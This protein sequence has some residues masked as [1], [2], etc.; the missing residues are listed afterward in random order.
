MIKKFLQFLS[1]PDTWIEIRLIGNGKSIPKFYKGT[2]ELIND[3]S[4]LK[5]QNENNFNVYYG[6]LPRKIKPESGGGSKEHVI[7]KADVLWLDVDV[8]SVK[9]PEEYKDLTDE[10][11]KSKV[12]E[13]FKEKGIEKEPRRKK[14]LSYDRI[15]QELIKAW[16][17]LDKQTSSL[18]KTTK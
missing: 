4:F 7:D 2:N 9:R 10:E 6:I 12:L 11:I 15:I 1:I 18:N 8:F 14:D 3:L 17:I 13:K 16:K 5:S